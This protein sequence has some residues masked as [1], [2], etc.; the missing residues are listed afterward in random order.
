MP[1]NLEAKRNWAESSEELNKLATVSQKFDNYVIRRFYGM[2]SFGMFIRMIDYQ[3]QNVNTGEGKGKL[4]E[5]KLKVEKELEKH[6]EKLL[7]DLNYEV[8]PI[9]KLVAVQLGAALATV[10]YL[11]KGR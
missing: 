8:I 10:E 4:E 3:L 6:N 5:V 11:M 9:R 1:E 7:K 2:L